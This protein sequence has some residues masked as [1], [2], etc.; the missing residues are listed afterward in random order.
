MN[1]SLP[2]RAGGVATGRLRFQAH[3]QALVRLTRPA[4]AKHQGSSSPFTAPFAAEHRPHKTL[5]TSRRLSPGLSKKLPSILRA[6]DSSSHPEESAGYSSGAQQD[7]TD[8]TDDWQAQAR[9]PSITRAL[10]QPNAADDFLAGGKGESSTAQESAEEQRWS[11]DIAQ[12]VQSE[13]AGTEQPSTSRSMD[14]EDVLFQ[15]HTS[16]REDVDQVV[17]TAIPGLSLLSSDSP[18]PSSADKTTVKDVDQMQNTAAPGLFYAHNNASQNP[19]QYN[20]QTSADRASAGDA[21][22]LHTSATNARQAVTEAAKLAVENAAVIFLGIA[23]LY[24]LW[25]LLTDTVGVIRS[26]GMLHTWVILVGLA[27]MT[28]LTP[29]TAKANGLLRLLNELNIF[30]NYGQA[31]HAL[32]FVTWSCI[33]AFLTLVF[34]AGFG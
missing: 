3:H 32:T 31:K 29:Q 6:Q 21:P 19:R 11:R 22:S 17:N 1:R 27:V 2:E 34:F 8:R 18:L 24:V 15:D 14:Y 9:Q 28:M 26:M 4:I 20:P 25:K 7:H 23:V 16:I 13:M 12:A 33:A 30:A 5:E 10:I